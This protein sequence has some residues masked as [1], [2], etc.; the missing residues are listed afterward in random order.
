VSK[1]TDRKEGSV[2]HA[3][4]QHPRGSSGGRTAAPG[5]GNSTDVGTC[6]VTEP[7]VWFDAVQPV[8]GDYLPAVTGTRPVEDGETT[9]PSE[10]LPGRLVVPRLPVV[11]GEGQARGGRLV[12]HHRGVGVEL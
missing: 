12:D 7:G 10:A 9:D 8:G 5:P 4:S 11:A 3:R 2:S 6:S 1:L